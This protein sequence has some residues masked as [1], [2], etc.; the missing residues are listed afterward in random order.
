M[1]RSR[2]SRI[3]YPKILQSFAYISH[4]FFGSSH[5]NDCDRTDH[6]RWWHRTITETFFTINFIQHNKVCL[7]PFPVTFNRF[8]NWFSSLWKYATKTLPNFLNHGWEHS[9]CSPSTFYHGIFEYIVHYNNGDHHISDNCHAKFFGTLDS[10]F[11][12]LRL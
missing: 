11:F 7:V 5:W 3:Y 12:N 9:Y 8:K 2:K 1:R 4:S 6:A 10:S